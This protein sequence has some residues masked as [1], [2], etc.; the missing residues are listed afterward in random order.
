[1]WERLQRVY[2]VMRFSINIAAKLWMQRNND[3]ET[4]CRFFDMYVYFAWLSKFIP[5]VTDVDFSAR[6]IYLLHFKIFYLSK[7]LVLRGLRLILLQNCGC[8]V[9]MIRRQFVDFS[10][11]MCI[12]LGCQNLFLTWQMS[13]FLRVLFFYHILRF[14]IYQKNFIYFLFINLVIRGLQLILLQNCGCNV[15][16]IR[17]QFVDFSLYMCILLGCQNLLSTWQ[18]SIFPRVYL[19]R[20]LRFFIYQKILYYAVFN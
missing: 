11:Y 13:I 9:I 10:L 19:Y 17:R 12:L 16:M 7:N 4:I 3:P 1:M 20:I 8:N 5:H 14:F 2:L 18:M 6:V 15:I